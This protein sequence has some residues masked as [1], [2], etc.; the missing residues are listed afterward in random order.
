MLA[1]HHHIAQAAGRAW[2]RGERSAAGLRRASRRRRPLRIAT[3]LIDLLA[4]AHTQQLIAGVAYY[5]MVWLAPVTAGLLQ[6]T[7]LALG[8]EPAARLFGQIFAEVLPPSVNLDG[9]VVPQ[10]RLQASIAGAVALLAL[11]WGSYKLFAAVALIVN[12]VWGTEP[13]QSRWSHKIRAYA[14]LG[15]V[16]TAL[17]TAGIATDIV[18]QAAADASYMS[19]AAARR[20]WS[21]ALVWPL[22][23]AAFVMV[24]RYLPECRA[25]WRWAAGGALFATVAFNLVNEALTL[26]LSYIASAHVLYWSLTTALTF[27]LWAFLSALA[28]TAGAALTAFLQRAYGDDPDPDPPAAT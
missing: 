11:C 22:S 28:L 8:P 18:A 1:R 24:Y 2:R 13:S 4:R 12:Y 5:A 6:V 10:G 19:E 26:F 9:L 14:L 27:M 16:G 25:Q 3:S 20:L 15:V 21:L 23:G 7:G 17:L